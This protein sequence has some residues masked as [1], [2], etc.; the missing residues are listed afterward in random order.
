MAILPIKSHNSKS[1]PG[2]FFSPSNVTQHFDPGT[3]LPEA[4]LHSCRRDDFTSSKWL[5][6]RKIDS[7]R[8][9]ACLTR[10]ADAW[11]G[12]ST[13]SLTIHFNQKGR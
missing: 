5:G 13:R 3:W 10:L 6:K 12:L 2:T 9:A 1:R 8:M 7:F 11:H 4:D